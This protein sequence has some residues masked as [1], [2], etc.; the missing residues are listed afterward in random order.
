MPDYSIEDRKKSLL[1]YQEMATRAGITMVHNAM[2]DEKSIAIYKELESEDTLKMR[3]RGAIAL[4][5]EQN[6]Q[7]QLEF[8]YQEIEKK[9]SSLFSNQYS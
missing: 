4:A 1:A 8:I 7:E 2:L 6:I 9:Y 3:F 5:P